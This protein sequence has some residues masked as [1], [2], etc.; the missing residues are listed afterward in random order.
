VVPAIGHALGA[1]EALGC[2]DALSGLSIASS[3]T[4]SSSAVIAKYTGLNRT[5][6]FNTCWSLLARG[7]QLS[8]SA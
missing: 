1:H 8:W 3:R 6:A 2:P 5:G 7:E 4:V